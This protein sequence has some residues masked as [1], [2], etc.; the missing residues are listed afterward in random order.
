MTQN[1]SF[2][3]KL[4]RGFL[5]DERASTGIIFALSILPAFG[6]I[7]CAID[8]SRAVSVRTALLSAADNANF[9]GIGSTTE[10]YK[11]AMAMTNDGPIALAQTDASRFFDNQVSALSD[12][13]SISKTVS[14]TKTGG[15]ITSTVAFT[16]KM[17]TS[18]GGIM[19]IKTQ[20]VSGQTTATNGVP[21]FQD[22]YL[23]LDDSPSMGVAA[24]AVLTATPFTNIMR[25]L[26]HKGSLAD[27]WSKPQAPQA[28]LYD[29]YRR[30]LAD[31]CLL[32]G[33]FYADEASAR[34]AQAAAVRILT[35][36]PAA[37]PGIQSPVFDALLTAAE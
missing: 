5:H 27:F 13:S 3:T 26:T 2:S 37:Q 14:V 1:L 29:A 22:F 21:V 11:A 8:Y 30:V 32:R 9:A 24:T 31:R 33:G 4:S 6:L 10:G 34:L 36:A 17:N 35:A 28:D 18:F 12:V 15:T 19:G 23:M 16:A 7:A 25:G 20:N